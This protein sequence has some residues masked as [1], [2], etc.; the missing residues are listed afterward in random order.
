MVAGFIIA[1]FGFDSLFITAVILYLISGIPYITIPHTQEK[2]SWDYLQTLKNFFA[3]KNRKEVIAFASDGA[4]TATV[5]VI[6]PIFIFQLLQGDYLKIGALSTFIIAFSIILQLALGKR[7]DKTARKEKVLKFGTVLSSVS[8]IIKIFI[9]TTLQIF[10]IGAFH[11]LMRIFTRIPF[12]TL[13]YE[14]A[15]DKGHFVDEFTVL[16]EI[17]INLGRVFSLVAAAI[18]AIYLPIQ[19][20]FILAAIASV[21]LNLLRPKIPSA[22][23]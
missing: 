10:I 4:E 1:R 2:F 13:S 22:D 16:R 12:D 3:K 6:W 15:A 20:L 11:N 7:L 17:A 5:I 23:F 14:I 8:W 21:F 9:E 19:Y 18:I